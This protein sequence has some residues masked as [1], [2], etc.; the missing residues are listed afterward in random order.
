VATVITI[1]IAIIGIIKIE[2]GLILI[3]DFIFTII[4]TIVVVNFR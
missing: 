3:A 1:V 2:S 4:I